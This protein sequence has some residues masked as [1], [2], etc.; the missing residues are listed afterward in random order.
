MYYVLVGSYSAEDKGITVV[1]DATVNT[2]INTVGQVLMLIESTAYDK[3][4]VL[5]NVWN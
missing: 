5:D 4:Q 3:L 1:T 2:E